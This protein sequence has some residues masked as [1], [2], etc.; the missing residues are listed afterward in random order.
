MQQMGVIILGLLQHRVWGWVSE[1][2]YYEIPSE[3]GGDYEM[4]CIA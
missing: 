1:M 2:M 4:A 3:P